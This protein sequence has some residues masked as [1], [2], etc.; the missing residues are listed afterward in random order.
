MQEAARQRSMTD[1][2]LDR[3]A[4]GLRVWTAGRKTPVP[5]RLDSAFP[6]DS[7]PHLSVHFCSIATQTPDPPSRILLVDLSMD[8]I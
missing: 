5:S 4:I 7:D 2:K 6:D 1:T 8:Y 3:E